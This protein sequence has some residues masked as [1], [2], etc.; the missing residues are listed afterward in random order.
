MSRWALL[1]L[2]GCS[3]SNTVSPPL[4]SQAH[5]VR[6]RRDVVLVPGLSMRLPRDWVVSAADNRPDITRRVI[7]THNDT[8]LEFIAIDQCTYG[9]GDLAGLL[10]R[11]GE[12]SAAPYSS[13]CGSQL[14]LSRPGLRGVVRRV[15]SRVIE[16][17]VR[18][19]VPLSNV[20][21]RMFR[22]S[23][24]PSCERGDAHASQR[25]R[26]DRCEVSF[27][28]DWCVW[29]LDET[30]WAARA[31]S[32]VDCDRDAIVLT[33]SVAPFL[34]DGGR[35]R[36]FTCTRFDCGLFACLNLRTSCGYR[37]T[38]LARV[39]PNLPNLLDSEAPQSE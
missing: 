4:T 23:L 3:P 34:E 11:P 26:V 15:D 7:H 18:T 19:V 27:P 33:P 39:H 30:S 20:E 17:Q 35:T 37:R 21:D 22:R 16:F 31:Q 38:E 12:E 29:R 1:A 14:V 9:R 2:L 5:E 10:S 13:D 32:S 24:R 28:A 8:R 25:I 36:S 6:A